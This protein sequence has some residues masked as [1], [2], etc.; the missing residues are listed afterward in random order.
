MRT[1]K[2][3]KLEFELPMNF[4]NPEKFRPAHI[5]ESMFARVPEF[6]CNALFAAIDAAVPINP[7][8]PFIYLRDGTLPHFVV[9]YFMEVQGVKKSLGTQRR[10]F[11]A[12][13]LIEAYREYVILPA[14][15]Y[16]AGQEPLDTVGAVPKRKKA[17]KS[18]GLAKES[19][20]TTAEDNPVGEKP[21]ETEDEKDKSSDTED[22]KEK[23]SDTV[24]EEDK[25]GDPEEEKDKSVESSVE[26]SGKEEDV[27]GS[28]SS[29]K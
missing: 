29:G 9:I 4:A 27:S 11:Q 24:E 8:T 25:S 18:S 12:M 14:P 1:L 5:D 16:L 3:R 6:I 15:H 10:F 13:H 21:N 2:S 28:S 23:S 19:S 22:E 26:K 20:A 7:L 17:V